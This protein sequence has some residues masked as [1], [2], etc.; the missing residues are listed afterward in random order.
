M[1][2]LLWIDER[3]TNT[4]DRITIA[5]C[6]IAFTVETSCKLQE[7]VRIS[8]NSRAQVPAADQ[9]LHSSLTIER[10]GHLAE[11][12]VYTSEGMRVILH[13]LDIKLH[14]NDVM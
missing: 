10:I 14:E 11:I 3:V 9:L 2:D 13:E 1:I 5:S 7:Q 12:V 6:V 4:A 8:L